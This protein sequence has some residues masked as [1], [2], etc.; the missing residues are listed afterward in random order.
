M[1]WYVIRTRPLAEHRVA[2][3]LAEKGFEHYLPVE[4]HWR[5]RLRA[6]P[7]ARV[8]KP[9]FVGYL[10]VDL[11]EEAPA[12]HRVHAMDG[13]DSFIGAGV[14][15]TVPDHLINDLRAIEAQGAFDQTR[16]PT[17]SRR[18]YRPGQPVKIVAG[19]LKGHNASV[20]EIL[21]RKN[22]RVLFSLFGRE[23]DAIIDVADLAA[24]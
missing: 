21:G 9:L 8:T 6:R 11:D 24:A 10:F 18:D 13:F 1:T 17:R 12:F 15:R 16:K 14:P 3:A 20:I 7:R 23:G 22:V 5:P 4:T 19:V 2:A